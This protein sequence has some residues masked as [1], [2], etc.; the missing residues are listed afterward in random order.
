MNEKSVGNNNLKS[1]ITIT[2]TERT[3]IENFVAATKISINSYSH[4]KITQI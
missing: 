4:L 1:S 3:I 2:K